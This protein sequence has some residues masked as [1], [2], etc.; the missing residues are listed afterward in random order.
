MPHEGL[1]CSSSNAKAEQHAEED[2]QRPDEQQA[3]IDDVLRG[4]VLGEGLPKVH[5]HAHGLD[6]RVEE[7]LPV[8]VELSRVTPVYQDAC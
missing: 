2:G 1:T 7:E 4:D 8:G 5:N 6:E 3:S